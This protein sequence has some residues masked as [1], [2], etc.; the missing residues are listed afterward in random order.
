METQFNIDI[1]VQDGKVILTTDIK[2][3]EALSANTTRDY[4]QFFAEAVERIIGI[5]APIIGEV[6]DEDDNQPPLP[7]L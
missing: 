6:V 3:L 2:G 1:A 5:S 4:S 7:G